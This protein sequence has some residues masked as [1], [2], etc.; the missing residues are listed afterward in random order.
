MESEDRSQEREFFPLLHHA[1]TPKP[2]EFS[3]VV[4]AQLAV[5]QY[6]GV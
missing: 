5:L 4:D 1:I 2:Q 6:S 3:H